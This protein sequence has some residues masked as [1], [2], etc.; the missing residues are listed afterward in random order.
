M[1]IIERIFCAGVGVLCI[2]LMEHYARTGEGLTANGRK[3]LRT[4]YGFVA[5]VLIAAAIFG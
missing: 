1:G 4:V 5:G 3:L 2:L